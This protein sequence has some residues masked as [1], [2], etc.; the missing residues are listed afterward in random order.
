MDHFL[1]AKEIA[2][3][4]ERQHQHQFNDNA[5]RLTRSI[6]AALGLE[7]IGVHIVRL[8]P[9][10]DSTTH[11]YHDADEEFIY[12]LSG[13]GIARIGTEERP[14][15]SGDFMAF[16]APSA[17]HSLRNPERSDEDLVYLVGG[18][19]RYPDVVHYPEADKVMIK[20]ANNER[21]WAPASAFKPLT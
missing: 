15:G 14:V 10:R 5:V 16:T 19:R 21:A 3:M 12:I 11:H 17:P 13:S 2:A 18:E 1:S 8:T 20:G 9:G 4:P 7:R 6:G